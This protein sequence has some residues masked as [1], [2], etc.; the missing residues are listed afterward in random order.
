MYLDKFYPD[1]WIIRLG[2]RRDSHNRLGKINLDN[3]LH[4][5][6]V[7][8]RSRNDTY[9]VMCIHVF[10]F[11]FFFFY[12]FRLQRYAIIIKMISAH[13]CRGPRVARRSAGAGTVTVSRARAVVFFF[14]FIIALRARRVGRSVVRAKYY[15]KI[16][17]IIIIIIITTAP[18]VL[19]GTF[20]PGPDSVPYGKLNPFGRTRAYRYNNNN[21]V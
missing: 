16:F 10:F 11:M 6:I 1:D 19:G 12:M 21:S 2:H 8:M 7:F 14:F 20:N 15:Y 5:W 9:N 3:V 17:P 4:C 13:R 18:F